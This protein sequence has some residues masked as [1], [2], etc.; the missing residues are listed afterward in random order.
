MRFQF[1]LFATLVTA[2]GG[3]TEAPVPD[4]TYQVGPPGTL[5]ASMLQQRVQ[6]MFDRYCAQTACH[7]DPERGFFIYSPYATR[8][9]SRF[10]VGL[11]EAELQANLDTARAFTESTLEVTDSLLL[12][13]PLRRAEGGTSHGGG[14]QFYD[15]GDPAYVLLTCWLLGGAF[16]GQECDLL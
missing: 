12:S 14:E 5:S 9:D 4:Q 16:D 11:T 10:S 2:C 1:M 15:R 13:R 7:G 6:P 8:L 3:S